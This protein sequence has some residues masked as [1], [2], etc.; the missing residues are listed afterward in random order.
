M[1]LLLDLAI[2][3]IGSIN[4]RRKLLALGVLVM[5]P[6]LIM[7]FLVW[8]RAQQQISQVE[9]AKQS[10]PIQL[11]LLNL[12]LAL[13]AHAVDTLR[14]ADQDGKKYPQRKLVAAAMDN[15]AQ[16][17]QETTK[18]GVVAEDNRAHIHDTATA[19]DNLRVLAERLRSAVSNLKTG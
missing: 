9:L 7:G 16:A 8:N 1:T 17:I 15:A 6:V 3:L 12:N 18:N 19:I 5:I 11:A 13:Q 10:L 4:F 14:L 2:R